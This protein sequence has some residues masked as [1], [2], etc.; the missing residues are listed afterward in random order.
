MLCEHLPMLGGT[1]CSLE[2]GAPCAV[3]LVLTVSSY[4]S[5]VP[6]F[7]AGK[8]CWLH[9]PCSTVA[10]HV[11]WFTTRETSGRFLTTGSESC[12]LFSK[13]P[14]FALSERPQ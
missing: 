4:V 5:F 10:Y 9:P 14:P 13:A 7:K 12:Q 1:P 3:S 11:A 2:L 6:T 8:S